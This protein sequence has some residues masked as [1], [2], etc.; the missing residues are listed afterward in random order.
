MV[1]YVYQLELP[2]NDCGNINVTGMLANTC[3]FLTKLNKH[4][5]R[6]FG[7][8]PREMKRCIQRCVHPNSDI[9]YF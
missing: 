6:H 5:S 7:I 8:Y 4:I 2:S 3:H 1:K 9:F